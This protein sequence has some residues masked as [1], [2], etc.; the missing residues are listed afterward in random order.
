[1]L[2]AYNLAFPIN[3]VCIVASA[4]D[5]SSAL[6]RSKTCFPTYSANIEPFSLW[7]FV[8][9]PS[10]TLATPSDS[11]KSSSAL[12]ALHEFARNSA[13]KAEDNLQALQ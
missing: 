12:C 10:P 2:N 1:M 13:H 6:C 8:E 4:P 3:Y 11:K 9:Q 7:H 5:L